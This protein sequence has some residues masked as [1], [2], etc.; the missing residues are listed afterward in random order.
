MAQQMIPL[1]HLINE[2]SKQR[3][4]DLGGKKEVSCVQNKSL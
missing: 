2:M 1:L 3:S 4:I